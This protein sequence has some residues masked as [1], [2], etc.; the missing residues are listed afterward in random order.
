M[1]VRLPRITSHHIK[2]KELTTNVPIVPSSSSILIISFRA[3]LLPPGLFPP[4]RPAD[5]TRYAVIAA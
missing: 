5:P 2:R 4:C 3:G 1:R